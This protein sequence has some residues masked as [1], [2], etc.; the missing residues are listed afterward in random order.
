MSLSPVR[1]VRSGD[2]HQI[3]YRTL[4][5][6]EQDLCVILP[7][8]GTV[9]LVGEPPARRMFEG[10]AR[11]SRVISFDRRGSGLSDPVAEPATLEEQMADVTA[12]LDACG[13]G[14]VVLEA[15]AEAAMLA[16]VFAATHP[17]RVSHLILM[18]PMARVLSAPGYEWTWASEEERDRDFV[19]PMLARWGSGENGALAAPVMAGRDPAFLAWWGR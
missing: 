15:E 3:A 19:G 5:A 13:S 10:F 17:E 18:H 11:H 6:E 8:L 7:S 4:G 2:G 14:R 9:E 16:V 1:Y 12:V